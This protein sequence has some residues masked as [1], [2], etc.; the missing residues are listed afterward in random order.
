MNPNF[1]IS[2]QSDQKLR[3]D[4]QCRV[5]SRMA[6]SEIEIMK[7][8]VGNELCGGAGTAKSGDDQVPVEWKI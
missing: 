4:M 7:N 5:S 6:G 8:Q 1:R 3:A 2:I